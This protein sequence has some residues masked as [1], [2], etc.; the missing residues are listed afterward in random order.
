[1]VIWVPWMPGPAEPAPDAPVV[2]SVTDYVP[3][4]VRDYPGV[5][6]RG[7]GLRQGW[8][9]LDGAIGLLLHSRPLSRRSGSLSFWTSEEAL[10]RYVALPRHVRIMRRYAELGQ[11]R[12]KRWTQARFDLD[13]ARRDA[14][15][16]LD[17]GG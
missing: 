9:A 8:F 1:M 14:R 2:V 10:E 12:A 13:G 7:L 6:L 16:W 17:E 4:S 5:V 3:R 11:L 15:T